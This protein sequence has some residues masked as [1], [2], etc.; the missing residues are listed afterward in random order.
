MT[1]LRHLGSSTT[2]SITIP[3]EQLGPPGSHGSLHVEPVYSDGRSS[4]GWETDNSLRRFHVIGR[5]SK[6]STVPGDV[7][8]DFSEKDGNSYL[9]TPAMQMQLDGPRGSL[10]GKK[11]DAGELST[12]EF[13]CEARNPIEAK[14]HFVNAVYPIL[15]HLSYQFNVPFFIQMIR[16]RDEK[17]QTQHFDCIGPFRLGVLTNSATRLWYEMQPDY[18]MYRE[19]KNSESDFYKFLCFYKI[20]EGLLGRMRANVHKKARARGLKLTVGSQT[21]PD[22]PHV[23]P[24]LRQYVGMPMKKFYDAL[25]KQFRVAIAHFMTA[26]ERVLHVSSPAEL[27]SFSAVAFLCDLCVRDLIRDH[28]QLLAQ[29]PS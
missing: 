23:D 13:G 20:M 1:G 26:D 2:T 15:D 14:A 21:V 25:T 5:L 7:R 19:A 24:T 29:L 6:T 18:S 22:S 12:I 4:K 8:G 11:N 16:V 9:I 17:Y 27:Y 3:S 28:E 10:I